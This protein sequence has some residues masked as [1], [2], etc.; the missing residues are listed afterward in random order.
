VTDGTIQPGS[1]VWGRR[2]REWG[3]HG[4]HA[5]PSPLHTAV[6]TRTAAPHPYSPTI[7]SS[8]RPVCPLLVQLQSVD[9]GVPQGFAHQPGVG[10]EV[11]DG[12]AGAL[13]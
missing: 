1:C 8:T 12:R 5:L 2:G 11:I 3:A 10:D 7:L 4:P 13:A 6:H 9:R